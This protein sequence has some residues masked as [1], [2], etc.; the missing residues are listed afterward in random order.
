MEKI[1]LSGCR[2]FL[3]D[4][5]EVQR[6]NGSIGYIDEYTYK[7]TLQA[8]EDKIEEKR[9]E[10][11]ALLK[12]FR[13][14]NPLNNPAFS[15]QSSSFFAYP[16]LTDYDD[17]CITTTDGMTIVDD[18]KQAAN[19]RRQD[20]INRRF[21]LK[22][23]VATVGVALGL[24]AATKAA[25]NYT[26]DSNH[27][28]RVEAPTKPERDSYTIM[29]KE[30]SRIRVG[31][32]SM[33]TMNKESSISLI[34]DPIQLEDIQLYY[35]SDEQKPSVRTKELSCDS[36]K[37]NR[38]AILSHD[39]KKIIKNIN[40]NRLDSTMNID[41]FKE[42]CRLLYGDDIKFKINVHGIIDGKVVYKQAGWTSMGNIKDKKAKV[43]SKI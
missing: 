8:T 27:H 10:L 19:K 40:V 7:N 16:S 9:N 28:I 21:S 26:L 6:E 4:A 42:N 17:D 18:F 37:I 23:V 31:V 29:R 20:V 33:H 15:S 11:K 1:D 32:S 22:R 43:Y 12:R 2:E 3:I 25:Y 35:S 38:I 5:Y 13:D 24:M 34:E 36:Y 14:N 30:K 41:D 39:G